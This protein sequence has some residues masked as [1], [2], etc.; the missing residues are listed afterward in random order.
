MGFVA[1]VKGFLK[2]RKAMFVFTA[3]LLLMA[4]L[5]FFSIRTLLSSIYGVPPGYTGAPLDGYTCATLGCHRGPLTTVT[6]LINATIPPGGYLP[7]D[8]Y[9]I[10]L[11]VTRPSTSIFGFLMTSHGVDG[12]AGY[13]LLTDPVR[14]Q[15]SQDSGYITHT[16]AGTSGNNSITWQTD[17]I[18]PKDTF[19]TEVN[20]YAALVT[21]K[22]DVDDEVFLT[23]QPVHSVFHS[24]GSTFLRPSPACY[25]NPF[26]AIVN[27]KLPGYPSEDI[28][29]I[30]YDADGKLCWYQVFPC[31]PDNTHILDLE[32]LPAGIWFLHALAGENEYQFKMIKR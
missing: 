1:S 16:L 27:L 18:A 23:N 2:T 5:G 15:Y 11:S 7:A 20:F 29:I 4:V 17:W 28:Q 25:P 24:S 6:G 12:P 32:A 30:I 13:F 8:T 31:R 9:Q 21:G 26:R 10:S 19:L 14:T 3:C 22:F